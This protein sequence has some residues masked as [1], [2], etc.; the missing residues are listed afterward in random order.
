MLEENSSL[1]IIFLD[2]VDS[3][4]KCLRK[5]SHFIAMTMFDPYV[6]SGQRKEAASLLAKE[7]IV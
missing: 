3:G 4:M 2:N 6:F 7:Q 1:E 5:N